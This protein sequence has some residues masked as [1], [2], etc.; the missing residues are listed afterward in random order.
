M[1]LSLIILIMILA[2]L[3]ACGV[4]EPEGWQSTRWG[5]TKNDVRRV[6][7][8][9]SPG[10][11]LTVSA[12]SDAKVCIE[13]YLLEKRSYFVTLHF[14]SQTNGL[15][16][17]TVNSGIEPDEFSNLVVSGLN[18]RYGNSTSCLPEKPKENT[19]EPHLDVC[20]RWS[21]AR[22]IVEF[23]GY[24]QNQKGSWHSIKYS[25]GPVVVV[26]RL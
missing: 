7:A 16:M 4:L 2:G 9:F 23:S 18:L 13:R 11:C 24:S 21:A 20:R 8:R 17:V 12:D 10:P 25:R 6:L 14:D 5:M 1:R 22:N 15:Y 26:D 19:D 3:P